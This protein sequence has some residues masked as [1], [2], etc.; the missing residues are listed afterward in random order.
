MTNLKMHDPE[1]RFHVVF[2]NDA[3]YWTIYE[4]CKPCRVI[5]DKIPTPLWAEAMVEWMNGLS[6][7]P[8]LQS[9][10]TSKTS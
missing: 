3:R 10:S 6:L 2:N 7:V 8:E 4:R 9:E 5:A 1:E